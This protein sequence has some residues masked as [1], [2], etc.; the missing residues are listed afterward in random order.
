MAEK[1]ICSEGYIQFP[2]FL[3]APVSAS[4]LAGREAVDGAVGCGGARGIVLI[5]RVVSRP[6]VLEETCGGGF[7]RLRDDESQDV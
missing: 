5:T 1:N 2:V 7:V 6:G 4:L 3:S